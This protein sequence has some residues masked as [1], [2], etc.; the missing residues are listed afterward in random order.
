LGTMSADDVYQLKRVEF[1][2]RVVPIVLQNANGPCPLLAIANV[3]LLQGSITLHAD[4]HHVTFRHLVEILGEHLFTH[5]EGRHES[6]EQ[7][8]AR[9]STIDDTLSLLPRLCHG[10][11]VNVH[12]DS[13]EGFEYTQEL[14]CFDA[15]GVMLRHGWLVD[16]QATEAAEAVG[17]RS[18]NQLQ[19]LLI[20]ALEPTP[21]APSSPE[22]PQP[23]PQTPAADGGDDAAELAAAISLSLEGAPMPPPPPPPPSPAEPEPEPEPPAPSAPS[24][25]DRGDRAAREKQLLDAERIREFLDSSANQ[26]TY[27]GLFELQR[28]VRNNMLCAFF[29]NC[30]FGVLF[31]SDG[32]LYVL[33][34]DQ[35]YAHEPDLVWEKLCEVDGDNVLVGSNFR[36]GHAVTRPSAVTTAPGAAGAMGAAGVP[37][38]GQ[39][40][41]PG[42]SGVPASTIVDGTVLPTPSVASAG[43][44]GAG[45]YGASQ[46]PA[47]AGDETD[48]DLAFALRLQEEETLAAEQDADRRERARVDEEQ[49]QAL[50][51]AKLGEDDREMPR[52][53][54]V[55]V[56]GYGDG[57]VEGFVSNWFTANE[58]LIRFDSSPS[59]VTKLKLRECRWAVIGP[60]SQQ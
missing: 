31:N 8:L 6:E 25:A 59:S 10:L 29:R 21:R 46:P 50:A 48:G 51:A 49:R 45:G 56:D 55:R 42:E 14:A 34:T 18:Y 58:F 38:M 19:E 37:V 30:H 5:A 24:A 54:R 23:Q 43:G 26:L 2:H 28:V 32:E 12:F 41:G 3:L 13:T 57:H 60:Y 53:T 15:F 7:A 11:D 36:V 22:P 9:Q 33:L 52:G 16:P 20:A 17:G 1:G 4:H 27:Y 47:V 39:V 44:Y 35:G 40:L